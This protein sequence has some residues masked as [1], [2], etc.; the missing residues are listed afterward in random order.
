MV[1]TFCKIFSNGGQILTY[2]DVVISPYINRDMYDRISTLFDDEYL[3]GPI[4]SDGDA[5]LLVTGKAKK[6]ESP[7]NGMH[8]EIN[9]ELGFKIQK[10]LIK[11]DAYKLGKYWYNNYAVHIDNLSL[12]LFQ[13]YMDNNIEED[14]YTRRLSCFVIVNKSIVKTLLRHINLKH[15]CEADIIGVA[16]FKVADVKKEL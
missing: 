7:A 14:D 1:Y 6:Y 12:C 4:Y 9:E 3:L 15:I 13:P 5:Q 10:S 11:Y 2:R 8:R 16:C